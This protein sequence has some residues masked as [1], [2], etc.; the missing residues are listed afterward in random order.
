M[1]KLENL[2]ASG[3]IPRLIAQYLVNRKLRVVINRYCSKYHE[4]G[5]S[6]RQGSVL[7]PLLWNV[8]FNALLHLLPQVQAN[9]DDC[10][11]SFS[12]KPSDRREVQH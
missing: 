11:L 12:Y 5:V 7:G 3:D 1:V 2:G 8:F 9:A 4:I 6:V 10:T